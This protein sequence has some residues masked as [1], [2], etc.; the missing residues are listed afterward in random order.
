MGCLSVNLRIMLSGFGSPA[1]GLRV[2][3]S[4]GI[5]A[6]KFCRRLSQYETQTALSVC[7]GSDDAIKFQDAQADCIFG[8]SAASNAQD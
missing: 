8:I 4:G 7:P 1:G 3:K 5:E 2:T 6:S